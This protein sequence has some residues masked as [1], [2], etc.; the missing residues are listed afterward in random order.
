MDLVERIETTRFVGV[1]FLAW[2][3]F[4]T[5]LFEGTLQAADK[6]ALELWLDAQ[7]MLQSVSDKNERTLLRGL[8]PS[9]TREAKLA[10]LSGKVPLRARVC[11]RHEEQDFSFVFDAV[12]FSMGSIKLP[13][14]LIQEEDEGFFE[15]MR[16]LEHL[17]DLWRELYAEFLSLRL[18]ELWESD[19]VPALRAWAEGKESLSTRAY[20]GVLQRASKA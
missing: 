12:S 13:V 7:L 9:A 3:W 4:K 15:R 2:L 16:L 11:L 5:E 20:R 6:S 17:D 18:S 10:L 14:V 1:E 8:A 19:L